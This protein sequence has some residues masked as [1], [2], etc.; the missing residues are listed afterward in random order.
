VSHTYADGPRSVA[1]SATASDED[2][3]YSAGN[4][5]NVTVNNV[6]P[7]A[8]IS[9]PA[10]GVR[11][12]TRTFTFAAVDPS[13]VDQAGSFTFNINWGDGNTQPSAGTASQQLG[14]VYTATGTYTVQ[15]TVTDKDGGVS[16]NVQQSI[17]ISA[18]DV[19]A[20]TLAIGG[21]TAD[22]N[23]AVAPVDASGNLSVTIN[24]A[25]QGTFAPPTQIVIYGQAGNDQIKLNTKKIGSTTYYV[26]APAA[27]F[28]DAGNDT[29]DARG[30]TANNILVGGAGT[31]TLQG[32]SGRDLLIGGLGADQLHGNGGDDIVI[33]NSTA[34]D[35]NLAALN[36]ALAEWVRTDA[37]YTTRVNHLNGSL[38]GGLNGGTVL[39]G[40]TV[41]DDA[42]ID[43]LY[44]DAGMDWFFYTAN[45]SNKDRLN[46]LLTGEIAT[47]Q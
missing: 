11:G 39:N 14:H 17:T 28:G 41:F 46:D 25:S 21:A 22:D 23:I 33:G 43:Q 6:A 16:A 10:T 34:Y 24:G 45:G 1:I 35:S 42:A 13:A 38:P 36:A 18:V 31:D 2:G 9:G 15:V 37:D 32:G 4:S 40:T 29:L 5:L 44:G 47:P 20:G 8:S 3:T 30:S 19:Q 26:T 7:T 12:Q 27:L